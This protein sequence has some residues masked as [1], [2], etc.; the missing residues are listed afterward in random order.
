AQRLRRRGWRAWAR[1]ASPGAWTPAPGRSP[2]VA[3]PPSWWTPAPTAPGPPERQQ[4]HKIVDVVPSAFLLEYR[5]P[6]AVT[7]S[8]NTSDRTAVA[9]PPGAVPLAD[10]AH[11]PDR[12]IARVEQRPDADDPVGVVEVHRQH[13][14]VGGAGD[15]QEAALPVLHRLARAFGRQPEPQALAPADHLRHLLDHAGRAA[16]VDRDHPQ[17]VQQP[18]QR[19]P[20]QL[21]LAEDPD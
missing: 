19:P 21:A 5:P 3:R 11:V 8:G 6:D 1:R 17:R 4:L 16:A 15:L 7:G 2:A 9:P 10:A 12:V 18:R 14:H 13:R 20:E